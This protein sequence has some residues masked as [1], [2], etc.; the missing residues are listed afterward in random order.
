MGTR[1]LGAPGGEDVASAY[2][3]LLAPLLATLGLSGRAGEV[4]KVPTSGRIGSPLLVLVGLGSEPDPD[5]VRRAAGNAAR[6]VTNAASV[7]LALPADEPALVRAVV[8]G[9]RLGGYTYTAYKSGRSAGSVPAEIVV[10][11]PLARRKDVLAVVEDAQLVSDAVLAARDWVNTPPADKTPPAFAD[12]VTAAVRAANKGRRKAE[13]VAV[14]VIDEQRLAELGC[15]GLLAVGSGSAAP[16]RLVE[17]EYSPKDAAVHLALVGKGI[18]FDSGG[19]TIKPGPSMPTAKDD[20]AGAAA[21]VQATLA[22]AALG[23]PVRISAFAALAENMIGAAAM[24]PGD[25]LTTYDGTTVEV[26]NTDA[27]GRLVL[28]D[29][30]GRAVERGPDLVVD[31]ATLTAHMVTA[32]GDRLS[33]VMGSEEVVQQVL[34][35]AGTAGEDAWPMPIPEFM[36]ERI[37]SSRIADLAQHDWIRWGGGLFAA[38]FLRHFTKGLP[39]AHLDIAGPAFNKGGPAGHWTY[40]A[41]G[42]GVATL[43]ELARSLAD[44]SSD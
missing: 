20:M 1:A 4:A 28:A 44:T 25:V 9:Y 39:W 26:T 12:V 8:E 15:G 33:G 41:T 36:Q 19:L 21:V 13:R 22:I 17:L 7:A 3:R 16:P 24:R 27:E 5:A 37:T 35:A 14:E 6:A 11:T 23:L 30:L 2:G 10:L 31:V 18:T 34:A 32:L 29:A 43:V 38:A 42:Y 40:G